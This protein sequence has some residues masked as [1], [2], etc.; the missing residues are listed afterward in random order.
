MHAL[1]DAD[2]SYRLHLLGL[3]G[4][5]LD[6][7]PAYLRTE[8][9]LRKKVPRPVTWTT[10]DEALTATE[11]PAVDRP[12]FEQR[13]AAGEGRE[14]EALARAVAELGWADDVRLVTS[15]ALRS[16]PCLAPA[17][18]TVAVGSNTPPTLVALGSLALDLEAHYPARVP[19]ETRRFAALMWAGTKAL[20]RLSSDALDQLLI[21]ATQHLIPPQHRAD[22]LA[23]HVRALT[24]LDLLDQPPGEIERTVHG[25]GRRR[26]DRLHR[27]WSRGFF[28]PRQ[29]SNPPEE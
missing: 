10:V 8:E 4:G 28:A 9:K 19:P 23:R 3:G 7:L 24:K 27:A 12:W 5:T 18:R 16:L 2:V 29:T 13:W 6:V 15:S 22:E 20:P 17:A 25:L 14:A 21:D 1:V 11:V 26:A